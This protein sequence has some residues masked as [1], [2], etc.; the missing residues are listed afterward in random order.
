[1]RVRF[2]KGN[3]KEESH[4]YPFGLPM[5]DIS[6]AAD[7]FKQNRKRYQGNEYIKELGLNWMDFHA[8]QLG[9]P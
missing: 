1:M 4:Y 5:G 2:T 8:R 6:G 9:L 3:L 7:G